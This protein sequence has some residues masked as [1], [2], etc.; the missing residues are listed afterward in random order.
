M[1]L[2]DDDAVATTPATAATPATPATA[3]TP[4]G[5]AGVVSA[6]HRGAT[7]PAPEHT[8]AALTQAV[9]ARADRISVDVQLSRDGVPILM[10]DP[11]ME[12]TTDVR[13][14][15]PDADP[16]YRP[17][18]FTLEQLRTLDAGS[19]Y[20]GGTYTGSVVLTL[21]EVLTELEDSPVG[22]YLEPKPEGTATVEGIGKAIMD[23]VARYP[24]WVP[25]PTARTPRLLVESLPSPTTR[26]SFLEAMHEAYP[27]LPLVLLSRKVKPEDVEAHPYVHE[28]DVRHNYL[29]PDI[30]AA[31]H[32][33]GIRV[34]VWLLNTRTKVRRFLD[35]GADG[36]VSDRPG[37]VRDLLVATGRTWTGT[38]WPVTPEVAR[39]R[40]AMPGTAVVD[41]R[42]P[43]EAHLRDAEDR[44]VRWTTVQFQQLLGGKWTTVARNA[45]DSHGSACVSLPVVEGMRVRAFADGRASTIHGPTTA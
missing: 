34:N 38:T 17:Q 40:L 27:D 31:A 14:K 4:A 37:I 36:I 22:L 12:R 24:G 28:I 7:A 29:T 3:A 10:H 32:S 21:E 39:V 2:D 23:L 11:S 41:G 13:Q 19:W 35:S 45:T 25:D 8:L 26:W 42:V 9:A 44:P 6:A 33:R 15:F 5:P 1:R 20:P 30:V 18:D 16:S 43:V